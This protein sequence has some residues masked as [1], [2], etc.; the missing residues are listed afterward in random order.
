[1][2]TGLKQTASDDDFGAPE[3]MVTYSDCMTLLLTFFVLLLSFSSFDDK[4]FTRMESAFAEGLASLGLTPAKEHDAL[5]ITPRIMF[6][7]EPIAG[8][9]KP[10]VEG[11]YES[12]PNESLD[13]LDFQNQRVF[14]VPSDKVFLG[15]GLR[16]SAHGRQMLAD[17]AALLKAVPNRVVVSEHSVEAGREADDTGLKRAWETIRFVAGQAGLDKTR[18]SISSA[19]TMTEGRLRDSGLFV[20]N[21]RT[22]RVLEI[23]ILERS[24]YR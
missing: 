1:M 8:S 6:N 18:F 20:T 22:E 3:W 9:E 5:D 16:M 21:P 14:L 7:Q 12:N 24:T 10:T 2:A 23:V 13:F 4:V 19:T 11:H 17:V 15:M